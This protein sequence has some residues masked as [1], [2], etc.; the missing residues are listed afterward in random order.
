MYEFKLRWKS[1]FLFPYTTDIFRLF[2]M[3][4]DIRII[5]KKDERTL[6]HV[7]YA[8]FHLLLALSPIIHF[9]I[10]ELLHYFFVI[11]WSN[12]I[13]VQAYR[14]KYKKYIVYLKYIRLVYLRL[15]IKKWTWYL[16]NVLS[17]KFWNQYFNDPFEIPI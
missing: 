14:R 2:K 12:S 9:T 17:I 1:S 13:Y 3:I 10:R 5:W 4:S 15:L 16:R 7:K 11:H 8:L 6:K